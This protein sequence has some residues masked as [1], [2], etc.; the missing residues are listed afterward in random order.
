M[1]EVV[2]RNTMRM[3]LRVVKRKKGGYCFEAYIR[4]IGCTKYEW[5]CC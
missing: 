5:R 1:G 2:Y 4:F 3:Q